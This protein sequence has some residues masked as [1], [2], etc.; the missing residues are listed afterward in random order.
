MTHHHDEHAELGRLLP[1][2]ARPRLSADRHQLL[3]GHLMSE[4]NTE[5]ATTTAPVRRHR[6]LLG[7]VALPALVGGLA[8]T[9]V[10]TAGGGEGTSTPRPGAAGAPASTAQLDAA[11]VGAVRLLNQAAD[12]AEHRA[13]VEVKPGQFV[14][15]KSVGGFAGVNLATGE[16]DKARIHTREIWLSA[17]GSQ[18]GVLL[19]EGA[20][21]GGDKA[22]AG[23]K[24]PRPGEPAPRQDGGLWLEPA[25]SGS[26]HPGSYGY[27]AALPTDPDALL[28][29]IKKDREGQGRNPDQEAFVTIGDILREQIVP[30]AVSAALHR[31]AARIPG[32]ELVPEAVDAAGRRGVA[33]AR[34]EPDGTRT[35]W[36]FDGSSYDYLGERI[37]LTK[38]GELGKAGDV[39]GQTAVLARGATDR[40]GVRP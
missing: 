39:A 22:G 3:R 4:I 30:P 12:A 6:S 21:K 13:P 31:A 23:G 14:Y 33:V 7:R 38:D 34:T 32:V 5:H 20:A 37:V 35:E 10:L 29:K 8:L 2:P 18:W 17:D 27:A 26:A 9:L 19:E 1:A 11:P 16:V 28:K 24:G 40:A 36:I 15:V 25:G